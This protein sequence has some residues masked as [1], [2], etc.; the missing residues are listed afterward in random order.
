MGENKSVSSE[1]QKTSMIIQ[2]AGKAAS[3]RMTLS[4]S[5]KEGTCTVIKKS[6][7]SVVADKSLANASILPLSDGECRREIISIKNT[8]D[9]E[10]SDIAS[11]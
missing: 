2:V 9:M 8:S 7:P 1:N 3:V 10:V 4:W 5:Q 11:F 6:L